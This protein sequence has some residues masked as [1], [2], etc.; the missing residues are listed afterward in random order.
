PR[1]CEYPDW[2]RLVLAKGNAF[3]VF[4]QRTPDDA[5]NKVVG[6]RAAVSWVDATAKFTG[7]GMWKWVTGDPNP[8]QHPNDLPVPGYFFH[9]NPPGK[10]EQNFFS[11]Q[12]YFQ[13]EYVNNQ[14][15]L[16]AGSSDFTAAW[17]PAGGAR[18]TLGSIGR[19]DMI[20]LRCCGA[21]G[22]KELGACFMYFRFFWRFTGV[23]RAS[24]IAGDAAKR[25]A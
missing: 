17:K 14:Q 16:D 4:D 1:I 15:T 20:S 11:I 18:A 7:V 2:S 3:D 22:D 5:N 10:T 23:S 21:A 12:P 8:H 24:T 9:P 6:A 13:Q 19:Y 25:K